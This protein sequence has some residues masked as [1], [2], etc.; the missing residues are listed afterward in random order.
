MMKTLYFDCSM[1]AA[2]DMIMAALLE[3]HPDPDRFLEKINGIG[4]PQ[5]QVTREYRV[6]RGV[7]GSH[8]RVLWNGQEERS[9]DSHTGPAPDASYTKYENSSPLDIMKMVDDLRLSVKVSADVKALLSALFE[10][11]SVVH[12]GIPIQDIHHSRLGTMD[13]VIDIVG[14]SILM[15]ELAADR[16]I[17][18]PVHVGSGQIHCRGGILPVPA[19]ATEYILRGLPCYKGNRPGEFC[20]PTG[21]VLLRHF[22]D[23][24]EAEP[25]MDWVQCG[26]GIGTKDFGVPGGL[27]IL[28]SHGAGRDHSVPCK[29]ADKA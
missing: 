1:G 11:E 17:S 25:K 13:A 29:N 18:S 7:K 22:A 3:L 24:F 14:V 12:G 6:R 16:V 19:P 23:S 27:K 15:E 20:T 5:A 4:I 8:M 10:A 2:G 26:I 21:A 28:F 9:F